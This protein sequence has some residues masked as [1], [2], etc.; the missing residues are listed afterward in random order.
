MLG[1]GWVNSQHARGLRS[2]LN[3]DYLNPASWL[4]QTLAKNWVSHTRTRLD[5]D[6]TVASTASSTLTLMMLLVRTK[7]NPRRGTRLD[8]DLTLVST[9][10]ST[11]TLMMLLVR[12]KW[13]PQ[14]KLSGLSTRQ[15]TQDQFHPQRNRRTKQGQLKKPDGSHLRTQ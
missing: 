9:A 14:I 2:A 1:V 7:R 8:L 15:T 5:L 10:S 11:F 4:N 12:T 3:S 6:L 13:N